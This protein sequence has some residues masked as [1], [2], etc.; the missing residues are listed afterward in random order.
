MDDFVVVE[1]GKRGKLIVGDPYFDHGVPL[2]IDRKGV[3][4]ARP[5]DLAVVRAG[6]GR[7]RLER[8]FGRADDIEAV[9]EALLVREGARTE[10]EPQ[11]P[12]EP[13]QEGRVD[14]RGLVTFTIDPETAK[15]F[16]DAL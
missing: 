16:D 13:S 2:V 5:G 9:L 15:D 6:R 11:A 10:F 12:P 4:D 7:A 1:V 3:G 14:L 8:V